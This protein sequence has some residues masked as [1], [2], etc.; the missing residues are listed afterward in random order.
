MVATNAVVPGDGYVPVLKCKQGEVGALGTLPDPDRDR[1]L[2][3]IEVRDPVKNAASLVSAWPHSAHALL[4][5]P[6]N[7]DEHDEAAWAAMVRDMFDELR[8]ASVSAVPVVT[9]DD[10]PPVLAEV[11]AA[12][13]SGKNGVCIRLDAESIALATPAAVAADVNAV[14]AAVGVAEADADLVVDVGLVRDSRAAMV[15]TCESALRVI[16]N[17]PSWR[18]VITAFSAFP[19]SVGDVAATGAVTQV[20]R[21]D[22]L[23]YAAIVSRGPS[24]DLVYA[25]YTV[26]TPIYADIPW[27]PIPSIRYA[28]GQWWNVH[29]GVTK[30]DR[31][32]QYEKLALDVV[33]SASYAGPSFSAGDQYLSDVAAGRDGPGNPMTY[34]RA[35]TSRHMACVLDRLATLGVP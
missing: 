3:L 17:L 13:A 28:D 11:A 24:R 16:P 4:V 6:L 14:L 21:E 29:R 9:P 10:G 33:A 31:S 18:N 20:V 30:S 12:V 22:A 26:G 19:E 1:V 27:A 15:A 32:R 8:T 23:A 7:V 35:A 2:P 5:H 34:V 25:D